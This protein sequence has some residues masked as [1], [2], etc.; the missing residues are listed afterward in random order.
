M[1]LLDLDAL[2]GFL[3]IG[4]GERLVE[5]D[6]ELTR[7]IVR[8]V[9]EID[10]S[11][12]NRACPEQACRE[13]NDTAHHVHLHSPRR[14]HRHRWHAGITRGETR[15][16]QRNRIFLFAASQPDCATKSSSCG[17]RILSWLGRAS[18]RRAHPRLGR[19][20]GAGHAADRQKPCATQR[21]PRQFGADENRLD[22]LARDVG[23]RIELEPR[24]VVLDHR[25]VGARRRPGSACGR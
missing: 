10:V 18:D 4:V 6:I 22:L 7:R 9:Q 14:R 15:S 20:A 19:S 16:S 3:L 23:E 1:R 2:A 8:H 24:A 5:L 13:R 11:G 17:C 21:M 12:E 25:N